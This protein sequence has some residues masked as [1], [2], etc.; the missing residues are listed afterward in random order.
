MK[1]RSKNYVFLSVQNKF[2]VE[3]I[4]RVRQERNIIIRERALSIWLSYKLQIHRMIK[5][6]NLSK[7]NGIRNLK[8]NILS[9]TKIHACL[10]LLRHYSQ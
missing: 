5:H 1:L 10:C 6:F 9:I 8:T 3:S 7:V 2:E 4:N